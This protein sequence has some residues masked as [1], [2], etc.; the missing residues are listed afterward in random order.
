M[1]WTVP[2]VTDNVDASPI[3][4]TKPHL[5]LPWKAKIGTRVVI[6]MAQDAGGNKAR[7]KFKV[8]V[9]GKPQMW[10]RIILRNVFEKLI[11]K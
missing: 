8:K 3:L 4:W 11:D 5:V 9:L 6:Y 1:N 10:F 7:C 2:E